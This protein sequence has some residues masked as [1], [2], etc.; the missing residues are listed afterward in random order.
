MLWS[1]K[2]T[3]VTIVD[4]KADIERTFDDLPRLLRGSEVAAALGISRAQAYKWMSSGVLPTLR[5]G[6]CIR[7]PKSALEEWISKNTCA[8]AA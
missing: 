5:R 7:V 4:M 1:A 6:R 8:P 3:R 2:N